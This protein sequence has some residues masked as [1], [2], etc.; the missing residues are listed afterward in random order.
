MGVRERE[1]ERDIEKE[2][3]I[4]SVQKWVTKGEKRVQ[5]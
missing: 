3:R 4:E 2:K 1:K 5:N